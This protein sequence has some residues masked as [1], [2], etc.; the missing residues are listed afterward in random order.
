[1]LQSISEA[2]IKNTDNEPHG[3]FNL[4]PMN[5][6]RTIDYN[7]KLSMK[8]AGPI[9]PEGPS[10]EPFANL[11]TIEEVKANENKKSQASIK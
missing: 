4:L 1:M 6:H 2:N 11:E 10:D 5:L 3:D 9:E 7:I 8:E